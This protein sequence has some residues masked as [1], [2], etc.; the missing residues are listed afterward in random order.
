[1]RYHTWFNIVYTA[2]RVQSLKHMFFEFDQLRDAPLIVDAIYEGGW[3]GNI[4]D[5]PLSKIFRNVGSGLQNSRGFRI[6]GKKRGGGYCVLYSSGSDPDWP[7]FIDLRNG[8]LTYYGDNKSAGQLISTKRGNKLLEESFAAV[9][10]QSSARAS[11]MPFLFFEKCPSDRSQR[12]VRFRG[13]AVPGLDGLSSTEDLVAVWRSKNDQRFQNYRAIF[14]ILDVNEVSRAWLSD[15]SLEQHAPSAWK[16]WRRTG[17]ARRLQS[18]PTLE[19]R[20]QS[21]QAPVSVLDQRL[22]EQIYL[23]F[24]DEPTHFEAFAAHVF[25]MLY[26]EAIIDEVTRGSV[27]GGRDAIGRIP[28]GPIADPI[29]LDFALEAKCYAPIVGSEKGNSVT[30]G[31]T[32]RLISRLRY[33]Q[34]GVLVTTSYVA[35]QAYKEIREDGHPVIIISGRDIVETIKKAGVADQATLGAL[36]SAY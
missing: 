13:L 22:I 20:N 33:R 11:V 4:A 25:H 9:H 26:P 32:K 10:D 23:H 15:T 3:A 28:L 12:S 27:D 36:L 17:E 18:L 14:S 16:H 24:K 35:R 21:E 34:F 30:V 31:D 7:D 29:Y 1:M 6:S 5:D 8:T 19:I 2:H